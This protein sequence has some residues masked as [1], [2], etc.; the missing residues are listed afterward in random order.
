[1]SN[2]RTPWIHAASSLPS[3]RLVSSRPSTSRPST[4]AGKG[5]QKEI[6]A[7]VPKSKA[8]RRLESLKSGLSKLGS[9]APSVD[10]AGGCFCQGS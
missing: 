10:S 2:N 1:M 5:K 3:D 8:V 7:T 4:P 6:Q 9:G